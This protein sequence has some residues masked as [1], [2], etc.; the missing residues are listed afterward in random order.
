MGFLQPAL[1]WIGKGLGLLGGWLAGKKAQ[2][3]AQ[4]RSPEEL[5]ALNAATGAGQGLM[6]QGSILTGT[7]LPAVQSSLGYYGTLLRGNRAAMS[8]ATAGP[9]AA[10]TDTYRGAERSLE[11]SGVR[12]ATRD[13]ASAELSRDRAG[14]I[15]S[16]VTG[17]QP[18]AASA[19]SD[20]GTN[21][22]GQGNTA[23]SNAGNLFSGLLGEG[24]ANR[25][26]ARSE[27]EKAGSSIGSFLFDI[28]SGFGKGG[29]GGG[30]MYAPNT[31]STPGDFIGG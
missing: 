11:R 27:G 31:S 26:Y 3:S 19:L 6:R 12:G 2:S 24:F 21:L 13:L 29:G 15:A 30:G 25:K 23:F 9:R 22:V 20:I 10:L 4:Q 28:L 14:K 17:V 1:P 18:G 5:A 16:L 7:G 8:E